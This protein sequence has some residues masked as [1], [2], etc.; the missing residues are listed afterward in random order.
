MAYLVVQSESRF[1]VLIVGD[2]MI[3]FFVHLISDVFRI[4]GPNGLNCIYAFLIDQNRKAD[5][6]AVLFDHFCKE[7]SAVIHTLRNTH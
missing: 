5:E 2:E 6:I 4:D 7:K 3:K 1:I